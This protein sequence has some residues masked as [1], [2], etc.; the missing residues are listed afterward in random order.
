MKKPVWRE[1][2]YVVMAPSAF[3][4]EQE[5]FPIDLTRFARSVAS[6]VEREK[7]TD[8]KVGDLVYSRLN[9]MLF[10]CTEIEEVEEPKQSG[11]WIE[12]KLEDVDLY[13]WP[14]CLDYYFDLTPGCLVRCGDTVFDEDE[15]IILDSIEE[16]DRL[17]GILDGQYVRVGNKLFLYVKNPDVPKKE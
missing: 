2:R 8:A 7:I 9:N 3:G 1:I 16:R 17:T 14:K 15:P 12:I 13:P 10:V 11:R 5:Y 4:R 6:L